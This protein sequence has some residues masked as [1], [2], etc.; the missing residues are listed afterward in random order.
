MYKFFGL[1]A[2]VIL[3][4]GLVFLVRKWPQSKYQTFSQHAAAYKHT[5]LY[6]ILLFSVVLPL[7]TLFFVG[8]FVPAFHL[9]ASFDVFIVLSAMA[10]YACTF[11]PEVGGRKTKAHQLLAGL[12][13]I[14]LLPP[15]I[16]LLSSR[17]VDT[18]GRIVTAVGFFAMLGVVCSL[19]LHRRKRLPLLLLQAAYF[20]AFLMPVLFVS[21]I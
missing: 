3:A 8:W 13:A 12:S 14:F 20:A 11:V 16:L 6:Y 18:V 5:I 7:L 2:V 19:F 21:Y 10:Q 15:M 9:S 17:D 4:A 1:W